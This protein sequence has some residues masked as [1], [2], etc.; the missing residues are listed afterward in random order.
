MQSI[1]ENNDETVVF[2]GT[3]EKKLDINHIAFN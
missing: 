3:S 2:G 1:F